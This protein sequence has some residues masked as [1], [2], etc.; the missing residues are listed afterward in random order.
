[1]ARKLIHIPIVHTQADLGS[2]ATKLGKIGKEALTAQ[3]WREHQQAVTA[4][5]RRL[6]VELMKRLK[7]ELAGAGGEKLRIYQDG[8]PASGQ[9]AQRIVEE[10]AKKGSPNYQ[11]VRE[12]LKRGAHIEKTEHAGLLRQEYRLIRNILD[13]PGPAEKEQALAA[14]RQRSNR[15]LTERDRFIARRINETLKEGEVGLL[16]IGTSHRVLSHLAGDIIIIS[17]S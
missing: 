1:M 5:W 6:R 11:I 12:L 7:K 8:L 16:F 14:Y 15:L 13:A 3:G 10:V 17:L 4:F 9:D 2:V